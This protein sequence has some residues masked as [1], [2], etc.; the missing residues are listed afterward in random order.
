[1]IFVDTGAFVARH[2]ARDQHHQDALEG[3]K[4]LAETK[5]PCY[6]SNFV[7][8]ETFT[9]L[10]RRA[11]YRFAA[12]RA[13]SIMA[14]PAMR[15]LRPEEDDEFEALRLFE[16]YSDQR[17]SFTD[18]ISFVLMRRNR[19]PRVFSFDHHFAVVGFELW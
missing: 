6:T 11:G 15:I 18:C 3:W 17:V 2:L 14:S 7:L 4:R 10:G 19:L 1:M 12:Q 8:D 5:P 16:K 13:R 9:L